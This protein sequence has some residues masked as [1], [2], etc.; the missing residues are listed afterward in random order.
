MAIFSVPTNQNPVSTRIRRRMLQSNGIRDEEHLH[1]L[2][3]DRDPPSDF[4]AV[5]RR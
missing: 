1:E 2:L 5:I 4:L 3:S